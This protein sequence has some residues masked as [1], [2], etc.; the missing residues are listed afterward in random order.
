MFFKKECVNEKTGESLDSSRI[1]AFVDFDK[2]TEYKKSLG[3]Y[4]S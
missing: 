2:V 4:Q 1:S 3:Y